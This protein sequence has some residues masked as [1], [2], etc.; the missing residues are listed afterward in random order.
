MVSLEMFL[1]SKNDRKEAISTVQHEKN[2][3]REMSANSKIA[4][5]QNVPHGS[6]VF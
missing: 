6:H 3:Q 5:A 4:H 2:C 1:L